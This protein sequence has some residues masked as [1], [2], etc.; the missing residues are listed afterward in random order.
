MN[1]YTLR[2]NGMTCGSCEK[3]IERVAEQ[4]GAKVKEIDAKSGVVALSCEEGTLE[5]LR[6]QLAEKGF[7]EKAGDA[8]QRGDPARV[9]TYLSS[10]I[11]GEPHVEVESKLVNYALGST[12]ALVV[13][14]GLGYAAALPSVSSLGA[15][16]P[17]LA[18]A[19]LTSVMTVFSYLHMS[20]YGKGISCNNGMMVGMTMGMI[21]GFMV[22]ALIGATNGMFIGSTVGM[23]AGIALGGNLGRCCGV[24]GT[25]EGVMAGLM[26]GIMGAMTSVMM[27]RENLVLFLYIL[28]GICAFVLGGLSYMMYRESGAAPKEAFST[29]FAGFA[30]TCAAFAIALSLMMV[31]GPKGILVYP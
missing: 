1:D 5:T 24:M 15:Y 14:G 23:A 20:S 13:L 30:A 18:L 16:M 28:F 17:L 4:N 25:M 11:A 10:I 6:R 21:S 27:L 26:A 31:Y 19:I 3:L 22:G 2:L 29:R 8:G 9:K 12:A 7:N